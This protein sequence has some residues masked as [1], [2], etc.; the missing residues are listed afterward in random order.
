MPWS[1]LISIGGS[2]L[3]GAMGDDTASSAADAGVAST[4]EAIAEQRRE[5]DLNRA[6]QA[7]F[8]QTGNAANQRLAYLMG[9]GGSGPGSGSATRQSADQI[10]QSLL[11]QYTTSKT[12]GPIYDPND[13]Y[14]RGTGWANGIHIPIGYEQGGSTIDEAGLNAAV[15]AALAAQPPEMVANPNDPAFGSLARRFT[16]ADRDA[17]PVY[18]SGLQFGLDQGTGAVN[19]RAMQAGNYDSGATLK[20]LT[21]YSNDYGTTKAEGAYN[22]FNTDNTNTYNR[23]AGLSGAGQ[24]ATNQVSTAGSNMANQISGLNTDAGTARAAGI[25]GSGNAWGNAI[26]GATNA[27]TNYLKSLMNGGG[28]GN[29]NGGY[30][31]SGQ[32][33]NNPSAFNAA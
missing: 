23:L 2:L 26:A 29:G 15:Q 12:G 9:L 8:M 17:D 1:S 24:T 13:N 10:R 22:R 19:A 20:A 31:Y 28:G 7:G 30:S 11:G 16:M 5:Y 21:R 18:Q 6:D 14:E 25:V 33:Y 32:S 4:R 27:G 3:S